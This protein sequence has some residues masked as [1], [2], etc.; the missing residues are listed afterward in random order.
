VNDTLSGEERG[1]K[2]DDGTS[3]GEGKAA[4]NDG[5]LVERAEGENVCGPND[6]EGNQ[7]LKTAHPVDSSDCKRC[8]CPHMQLK[9]PR[10]GHKWGPM[11]VM[12]HRP[13]A[14]TAVGLLY[15]K[16]I[17]SQEVR[18]RGYRILGLRRCCR[19]WFTRFAF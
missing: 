12:V 17:V 3:R 18:K 10:G 2:A 19:N 14:W 6:G 7:S 15:D 11:C 4:V 16:N 13:T 9:S 8:P 5:Y 1:A